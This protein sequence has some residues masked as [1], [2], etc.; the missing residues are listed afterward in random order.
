MAIT[1][2][3]LGAG[4][5]YLRWFFIVSL[6]LAGYAVAGFYGV[7]KLVRA[8]L[9][10]EAS[11]ALGAELRA[12][13]VEFEPFAFT[14]AIHG[15]SLKDR[16]GKEWAACR[17]LSADLALGESL[18]QGRLVLDGR[19]VEPVLRPELDARGRLNFLALLPVG[20]SGGGP[21]FL[22]E[23]F[24]LERGRVEFRDASRGKPYMAVFDGVALDLENLGPE[25]DRRARFRLTAR[26]ENRESFTAEGSLS[27]SPFRSEGKL[28]AAGVNPAVWLERLVPDSP[29][30]FRAGTVGGRADYRLRSGEKPEFE[31]RSGEAK[32]EGLELAA[33]ADGNPWLK[34][35][36]ADASGFSY[37]HTDRLLK[38]DS[39]KVRSAETPAGKIASL[40]AE[41]VAYALPERRMTLAAATV[42]GAVAETGQLASLSVERAAYDLAAQRL[43]AGLA[44]VREAVVPW[45]RAGSAEVGDLR[46]DFAEQRV[47]AASA[48]VRDLVAL[49]P[50][51]PVDDGPPAAASK[52]D[53]RAAANAERYQPRRARIGSLQ[54]SGLDGSFRNR[55]VA[56]GSVVSEQAELDLRRLPGGVF[57]VRGWPAWL[58]ASR[59]GAAGEPPWNVDIAALRLEGYSLGFRDE[60]THPAVRV[61][62]GPGMLKL[63][64]FSTR[65]GKLCTFYLKT[66]V[67]ESGTIEVDGQARLDPWQA[68]L[69]FGV[70]QLWLRSLQPY[71]RH[72]TGFDLQR[73]KLNLWGDLTVRRDADLR[74]DYSGGAD[75]VDLEAV[76]RRKREPL[77]RWNSLKFEGLVVHGNPRRFAVRT[78]T[79]EQPYARVVI[80]ADGRLNLA[81]DLVRS[82]RQ[83]SPPAAGPKDRWPVV[84]GL[85][86]ARDGRMDFADQTLKPG[87][88]AEIHDL[89]GTVSGLSSQEEARASLLLEGR[90]N[91][92]SPAKI[93]GQI[94]PFQFRNHTDVTLEF[95]GLNLT[96]LS[97][98]SGKFAGYRIEKGKL[99]M[100]LRYRLHNH[101]LQA[102]NRF[103]LDQLDLGERVDSRDATTLPVDLAIALLKDSEGRIDFDLPISGHLD[104]PQFSLG[105]LY[106]NA[107]TQFFRKLVTSPFAL[108]GNLAKGDDESLAFVK[109]LPGQKTLPADEKDK[110]GQVAKALKARPEL[111]LNIK[112]AADPGEDRRAL[113]EQGLLRQ[114]K[115]AR[116]MELREQGIR[117]RETEALELSDPDYRRLFTR[118]YR[119]RHPDAPELRNLAEGK[120]PVLDG[121]PLQRARR[122]VMAEWEVSETELRLL[123]Q[124]RGESIRGF[125]VREEGLPDRRIYLLDVRLD[126][127]GEG[128]RAFLS[129]SG[130]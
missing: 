37:S 64:D 52:L 4:Q 12:E 47:Q 17:E 105:S 29:W 66:G 11:K 100:N 54:V 18:R 102:E 5:K 117:V 27:L 38:L 36:S 61:N 108:V 124:A 118:F 72:R 16:T 30:R 98:Y 103:V 85:L 28:E 41:G 58:K 9:L 104:D 114:L 39:A 89:N 8:R 40:S 73:G 109:F 78:L 127:L 116:R 25:P 76:D 32:G 43:E 86:R 14:L 83:P 45:L 120:Q 46:Y 68:D 20:E 82:S 22:V 23:R 31:I 99:D 57:R 111:V 92:N 125:L 69:R 26:G 122:K 55:S 87:F 63:N 19:L 49:G 33:R 88:M 48:R 50:I 2:R 93:Y 24:T 79:A 15:F 13:R 44:T 1:A 115:T 107:F 112:G 67:G 96:A 7:P 80:G 119:Q 71:W 74:V 81:R 3:R 91:G 10:P 130:S 75:L 101:E 59:G 56:I 42:Q 34:I 110:L 35:A 62:F 128:G 126:S 129:L 106:A 65:G 53:G 77:L 121:E 21:P 94:N 95:R 70:D 84:I 113:A 97:A 6:L 51:G 90:I 60:T 123:A